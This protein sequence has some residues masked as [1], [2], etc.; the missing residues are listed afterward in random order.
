MIVRD[1]L[2]LYYSEARSKLEAVLAEAS[3]LRS[4]QRG[5]MAPPAPDMS[6][7]A[8]SPSTPSGLSSEVA[9]LLRSISGEAEAVSSAREA[10]EKIA[11][12]ISDRQYSSTVLRARGQAAEVRL[13][14]EMAN[15]LMGQAQSNSQTGQDLSGRLTGVGA[16][17]IAAGNLATDTV[18]VVSEAISVVRNTLAVERNLT[19]SPPI[20]PSH[21]HTLTKLRPCSERPER[22]WLVGRRLSLRERQQ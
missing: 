16:A 15:R 1:D 10:A 22:G 20:T 18:G 14:L 5:R 6:D 21:L 9:V 19:V 4:R 7:G 3:Q 12:S 13:L 8:H 2:V 11:A 17:L